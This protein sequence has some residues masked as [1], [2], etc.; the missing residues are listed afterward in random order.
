MFRQARVADHV[1]HAQR[2][3]ADNLV[4]VNQSAGQ[5]VQVVHAAIGDSGV[6]TSH[7][8][9]CLGA[10]GRTEFLSAQAALRFGE[11]GGVFSRV[12]GIADF[13]TAV[14]DQQ[15]FDAY[16]QPNRFG[17]DAQSFG[18]EIAQHRHKVSTSE[19]SGNRN[20]TRFAGKLPTPSYV[21]GF[22]ALG[23]VQ[24]SIPVA[25]GAAGKLKALPVI[26]LLEGWVA[27][28][29]F[30]KVL[31]RALLMP[32]A[33]LERYTRDIVQPRELAGLFHSGQFGVGLNIPDFFL[34]LVERIGPPSQDVVVDK[35]NA[36]ERMRQ[37]GFL[38]RRWVETVLHGSFSHVSHFNL[39]CVRQS[40]LIKISG[41]RLPAIHH[42]PEGRCLSRR[43]R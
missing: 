35:T 11:L 9:F 3:D 2:F 23:D 40:M 4:L 32:K 25:E 7:L 36:A 37:Q 6:N 12:T 26:F 8:C 29:A 42:L 10:I 41:L 31:E 19:I 22:L 24:L 20:G 38:L 43:F 39:D 17:Y 14:G 13:L 15:V 16:V 5:L 30:K 1:F 28:A 33:L 18:F 34:P 27:S 21:Q